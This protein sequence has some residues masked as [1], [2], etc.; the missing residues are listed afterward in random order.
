[1]PLK[2]NMAV[3]GRP[4]IDI[5]YRE[6]IGSSGFKRSSIGLGFARTVFGTT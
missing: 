1:M 4:R 2:T 6:G 3:H 5:I